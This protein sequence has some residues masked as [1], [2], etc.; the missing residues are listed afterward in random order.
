MHL[1]THGRYKAVT[2]SGAARA[3]ACRWG[4]TAA[5]RKQLTQRLVVPSKITAVAVS[6]KTHT[7]VT[8]PAIAYAS[9][10]QAVL[11]LPGYQAAPTNG[12]CSE[13]ADRRQQVLC[14]VP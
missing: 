6:G 5:T 8:C 14:T 12:C 2:L 9:N 10:Q 1:Q 4:C 3:A 7:E 11:V 13:A